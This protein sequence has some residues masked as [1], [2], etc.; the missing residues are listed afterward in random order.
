MDNEILDYL[1]DRLPEFI[2]ARTEM[3]NESED[4]WNYFNG[5]VETMEHL[6]AKFS[7]DNK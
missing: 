7:K 3:A 4:D 6:I 1:K 2:Q 5:C